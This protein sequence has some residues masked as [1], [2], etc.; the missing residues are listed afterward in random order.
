MARRTGDSVALQSPRVDRR[1]ALGCPGSGG[2]RDVEPRVRRKVC[3]TSPRG[4]MRSTTSRS[5][6][7]GRPIGAGG[8][9]RRPPAPK[10][11]PSRKAGGGL[12]R[13]TMGLAALRRVRC[14]VA[15]TG[16]LGGLGGVGAVVRAHCAN[17]EASAGVSPVSPRRRSISAHSHSRNSSPYRPASSASSSSGVGS[18]GPSWR[19][20]LARRARMTK[21]WSR[22]ELSSPTHS[23]TS[24]PQEANRG[25]GRAPD[26]ACE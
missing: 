8:L 15:D 24:G 23:K 19:R 3:L 21:E 10:R 4:W 18:G 12:L 9:D 7:E 2:N 17:A 26:L 1:G 5:K 6:Q 20:P 14:R 25:R 16:R 22:Q 13:S 11:S